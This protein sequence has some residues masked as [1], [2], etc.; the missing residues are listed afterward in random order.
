MNSF[1][2]LG[3]PRKSKERTIRW[4]PEIK[5]QGTEGTDRKGD[6]RGELKTDVSE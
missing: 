3:C 5:G 2:W 1:L 4:P 6:I